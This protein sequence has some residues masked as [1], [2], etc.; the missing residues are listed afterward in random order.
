MSVPNNTNGTRTSI[1]PP[2]PAHIKNWFLLSNLVN[3]IALVYSLYTWYS[4]K[5]FSFVNWIVIGWSLIA[6]IVNM[7]VYN[8]VG[9]L[10][11]DFTQQYVAMFY[12]F[13][14][15]LIGIMKFTVGGTH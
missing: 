6:N 11:K 15:S 3:L 8:M 14:W 1:C 12:T 2:L 10:Y 9:Q 7:F 4:E 5:D 13:L